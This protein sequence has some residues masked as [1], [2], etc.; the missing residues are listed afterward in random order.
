M[1]ARDLKGT[2]GAGEDHE[3]TRAGE[4]VKGSEED[5]EGVSLADAKAKFFKSMTASSS[6]KSSSAHRLGT[7]ILPKGTLFIF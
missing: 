1:E 6:S 3:I 2:T 5:L 7:S 4:R